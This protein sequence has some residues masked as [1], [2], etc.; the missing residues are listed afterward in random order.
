VSDGETIVRVAAKGDGV[1][2]EGRHVPLAAPGDV[3]QPDG[4]L[5]PGPHRAVPPCRHFPRCGGCQLQH[6][7]EAALASFV[8]DRVVLAAEGQG[9]VA[10]AIAAPHLSPPCSRRRATLHAVGGKGQPR[11]GFRESGSHFVV[12]MHVCHVLRHEL[13]AL[14]APLRALLSTRRGR[15]TADIELALT[16][17]GVDVGLRNIAIEGLEQSEAIFDFARL[18]RLARLTLDMGYGAE[19]LWEPEPVT[20]TLGGVPVAMPPGA[21]LQAT[22]DGEAALVAAAR[23]WL[24][25]CSEVADLFAG[26]GTFAFAL[27]GSA[28]VTGVEAARDACLASRSAASRARLPLEV[29]HRDL[30][31]NPLR[32]EELARF[33]GV[34]LDPPR[35]GA[36]EQVAQLAAATVERIV[37]ISCN[38][39]S[40]S[41]DARQLVDAGFALAELRPVGQFRWSTHVELASLF[42]R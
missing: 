21:F 37:Y 18:N 4:S 7:D 27:A 17:Q 38:P 12:D 29:V 26:L 15:W 33:G 24:A 11:I 34:V 16:D 22:A 39:A 1:T 30:F 2:A 36:R 28:R 40:W 42:V 14:V 25:G 6:L 3:V 23:E 20:V 13:F 31:R 9:L 19:A 35:A 8:R 32:P 41:R 5:E 10:E